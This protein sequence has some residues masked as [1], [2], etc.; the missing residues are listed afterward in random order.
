MDHQLWKGWTSL[1]R[2]VGCIRISADNKRANGI[3]E[4]SYLTIR[5]SLVMACS[6][7][8]GSAHFLGGS[9]HRP[10]GDWALPFFI[11]HG[12]EL[13]LP[14]D[15]VEVTYLVPKVGCPII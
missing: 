7:D 4:R 2:S 1:R 3:V 12:V 14:F 6:D 10:E 5:E 8:T 13:V 15:L 9:G 11:A